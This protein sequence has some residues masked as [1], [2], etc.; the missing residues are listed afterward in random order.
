MT[1]L[2]LH[3]PELAGDLAPLLC[4]SCHRCQDVSREPSAVILRMEADAFEAAWK[5]AV[6]W[7]NG[8]LSIVTAAEI[9]TLQVLLAF[10]SQLAKRGIEWGTVP[11]GE[12]QAVAS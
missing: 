8:R 9:P 11:A 12:R 7:N 4:D 5:R 1:G 10:T 3:Y 2:H 6:A